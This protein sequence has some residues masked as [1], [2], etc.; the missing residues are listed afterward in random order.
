MRLDKFLSA[1]THYSRTQIQQLVRH[2]LVKINSTVA[3]KSSLHI[4]EGDQVYVDGKLVAARAPRYLMLNKP[5]G[6]V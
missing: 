6:Y 1:N 5:A 2:G 3:T 4:N